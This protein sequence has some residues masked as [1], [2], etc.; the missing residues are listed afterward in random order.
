LEPG[1]EDNRT[2]DR[3]SKLVLHPKEQS[4]S[5]GHHALAVTDHACTSE[6]CVVRRAAAFRTD[7][8]LSVTLFDAETTR[9]PIANAR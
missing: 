9:K 5:T 3:H 6:S 1:S 2:M 4:A 8:N 7:C